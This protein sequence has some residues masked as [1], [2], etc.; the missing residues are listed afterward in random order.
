MIYYRYLFKHDWGL[1]SNEGMVYSALL[2]NSLM[3]SEHF[4][5]DGKFN[6]EFAKAFI[7]ENVDAQ[8]KECIDYYPVSTR[9]LAKLLKMAEKTVREIKDDLEF[10]HHLVRKG[11]I[12]CPMELIDMG[13]ID[14]DPETGLKGKQLLFYALLKDRGYHLHGTIDTWAVRLAEIMGIGTDEKA[15]KAVHNLLSELSKKGF[16][17]RLPDNSLRIL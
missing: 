14:V 11:K 13:Y 5:L 7:Q 8:G 6:V 12:L 1:S 4:S 10:K 16:V 15:K 9:K 2:R 17:K 3:T